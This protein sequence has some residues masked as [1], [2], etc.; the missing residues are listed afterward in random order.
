MNKNTNKKV[1]LYLPILFAL[2]LSAGIF[3]GAKLNSSQNFKTAFS[4]NADQSGKIEAILRLVQ[5]KY[6]DT[7][8]QKELTEK[9]ITALLQ[10]LDPHSAYIPAEEMKASNEP[11]QGNFQGIGI[12]FN[13]IKDTIMVVSPISG[14]PSEALGI[15]PGDRIVKVEGKSVAGIKITNK[16]VIDKLRG[17]GGTKVNISI[18]RTGFNKLIDYTITRGKIPIYSVDVA[19]ML[20]NTTGYIKVSRFAATTYT[21]YMNGFNK[22]QA[23]GM[24]KLILD[25]R[26]NPGGFLNSAVD[27]LDE[28]LEAGKQ[29]VY[30]EGQAHP[31]QIFTAT[32]KGSFEKEDLILLIDEGSASASE[33]I[34]GAIQDN[35]RGRIVG[36][37]SFGK[38]LVQEQFE[39]NDGSAIRLTIARYFTPTG[40]SIQKPYTKGTEAYYQEENERFENGELENADSIKFIDSL[41]Y[42]TLGGRT[43]YGGG[44]IMP[45]IFVPLDTIGRSLYL[46]EINVKG[47]INQFAFSYADKERQ[48]LKAYKTFEHFNKTFFVTEPILNEFIS[49]AEKNG[50]KRNDAQIVTSKKIIQIQLKALIARNIWQN[51]GFFP[52]I[53]SIDNTLQKAIQLLN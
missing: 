44:G 23:L 14:G 5:Q 35:D 27:F 30:T 12:E 22:L 16:D 47:L 53:H 19:Y 1:Y 4:T 40:R 29:I 7:I 36:R 15:L 33:I 11:L 10:N 49:F 38:G 50:I 41:K 52:V 13:L 31:K 34:S 9:A 6:V 51:D 37:R 42:K 3:I 25:L 17:E 26:G 32:S 24:T 21:E 2:L 20:N 28:F 18:K 46:G 45:D 8:N 43:V 48:Q 39:F